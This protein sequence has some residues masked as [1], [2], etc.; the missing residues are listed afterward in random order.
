MREILREL[1]FARK[2]GVHDLDLTIQV[3]A[4]GQSKF[5]LTA[6]RVGGFGQFGDHRVF[7]RECIPTETDLDNEE[8]QLLP[9]SW[10][11]KF[12]DSFI[13][14]YRLDR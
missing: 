5:I 14:D 4:K 8:D 1:N 2:K 10:F 13:T 12:V 9:D 11:T 7:V 6:K 3:N